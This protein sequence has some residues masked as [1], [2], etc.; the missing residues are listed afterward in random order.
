[1]WLVESNKIIC[2]VMPF[3]IYTYEEK[4]MSQIANVNSVKIKIE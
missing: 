3:L 4:L 2:E 1:M